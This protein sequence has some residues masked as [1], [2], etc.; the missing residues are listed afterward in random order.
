MARERLLAGAGE[1]TIH[2]NIITADTKKDKL[3]NWWYYNK[4]ILLLVI[5]LVA[6]AVS[7][8]VSIF[9]QEKPDYVIALANAY[10]IDEEAIAIAEKH[11]ADY[12]EDLNGDGKVLVDI[13]N[14]YFLV[15]DHEDQELASSIYEAASVKYSVDMSSGDSMIW[16]Y[17]DY[18]YSFM[19]NS[20]DSLQE[21]KKWDEIPGLAA[22]DFSSYKNDILTPENMKTA[23]SQFTVAMRQVEG[24]SFEGNGK[25]LEYYEASEKLLENLLNNTKTAD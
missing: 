10:A 4:K 11:M 12:G 22:T 6:V 21:G 23:F 25:K 9:S 19:M 13:R 16:L 15:N 24:S 2:A 3:A 5:F 20:E 17:D 1:D 14:Y 7:V 18:G 8:A